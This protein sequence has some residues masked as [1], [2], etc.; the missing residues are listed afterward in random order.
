MANIFDLA[1][2]SK[3]FEKLQQIKN[4]LQKEKEKEEEERRKHLEEVHRKKHIFDSYEHAL[5]W[6]IKTQNGLSW[7]DKTLFWE[8]DKNKFKSYEQEFD[9]DGIIP[10]DVI[11]YYTK[12]QLLENIKN[13]IEWCNKK[14]PEK[15]D[16][17]WWLDEFGKLDYVYRIDYE[18]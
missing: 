8:S 16:T 4:D 15:A 7:H 14:Y 10:Y 3:G 11:K 1:S 5:D 17:K 2:S 6:A 18:S 12:E 9:L 13:H